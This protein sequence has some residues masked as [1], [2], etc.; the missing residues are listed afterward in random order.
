MRLSAAEIYPRL[1]PAPAFYPAHLQLGPDLIRFLPITA[2]QYRKLSFLYQHKPDR[3]FEAPLSALIALHAAQGTPPPPTPLY[4]FHVGHCGSTLLSRL[5]AEM[6]AVLPLREPAPLGQLAHLAR[7]V[8]QA[9]LLASHP[10]L[11][12]LTGF[13]LD[14]LARVW[15]DQARALIKPSS[16]CTLL[17][18]LLLARAP[19]ARAV[20]LY[21]SLEEYLPTMLRPLN[22]EE[23]TRFFSLYH[24]E[25]LARLAGTAQVGEAQKSVARQAAAAWLVNMRHFEALLAQPQFSNR[26]QLLSLAALLEDIAGTLQRIS[27]HFALPDEAERAQAVAQ[28]WEN[29][30][31]HAKRIGERY[32]SRTRADEVAAS[33]AAHADE[34][35]DALAWAERARAAMALPS[36]GAA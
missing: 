11:S 4:I 6:H 29:G 21:V 35:A 10:R 16:A 19:A 22:R 34:I 9:G 30:R 20:L 24:A 13:V 17:A 25:D 36:A 3:A 28:A 5:L 32:D 26:V 2:D 8:P 14:L 33:R 23:V 7:Q 18:P 31:R 1:F 27:A 12:A 15:P